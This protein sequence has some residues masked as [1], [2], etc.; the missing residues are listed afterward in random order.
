MRNMLGITVPAGAIPCPGAVA[1]ILFA[2]SLH[3]LGIS[4]LA[5]SSIS[6]GMGTT[7]AV[8]G[9]IAILAKR[10]AIRAIA[11]GHEQRGALIRTI[12][13]ITERQFSFSSG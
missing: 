10:G 5:V 12:V 2:L 9:I 13:E 6:L 3:M 4:V 1:V 7:I 8:T 11:V